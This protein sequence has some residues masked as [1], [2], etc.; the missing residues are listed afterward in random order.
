MK[1]L[2][3]HQH[4]STP[5]G[6]A[7]IRSYEMA[8]K[9]VTSGHQV[10]MVCGSY[11]GGDTGL[12]DEFVKGVRRGMVDGFEVVEFEL[13]YSNT[14]SFSQRIKS[15]LGFALRSIKLS[16]TE[17]YD[18]LFA[19]TTPLTAA[20][21]GITARWFRR[22]PFVFEVRDLWPELPREMGVITNP[23]ILGAM[24]VL[25]WLAYKSAHGLVAFSQVIKR[26][27]TRFNIPNTRVAR[28]E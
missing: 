23:V 16:M 12:T 28:S 4:F 20:L 2:Y 5:K 14:Q 21:P 1:V 7:G 25:E 3:F 11:K 17:K 19:T 13:E 22:K 6:S 18:L 27:I 10:T 15:F 24:G 9:L 8:K 26:G